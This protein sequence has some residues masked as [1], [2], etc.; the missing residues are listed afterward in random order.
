MQ[1]NDGEGTNF[2]T[3]TKIFC[4]IFQRK[5]L[6]EKIVYCGAMYRQYKINF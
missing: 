1:I 5:T 4:D 6:H 2:N 3:D